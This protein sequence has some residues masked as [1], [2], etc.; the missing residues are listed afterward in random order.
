MLLLSFVGAC[1]RQQPS[2]ETFRA[3]IERATQNNVYTPRNA[4]AVGAVEGWHILGEEF[5]VVVYRHRS[6]KDAQA[7]AKKHSTLHHGP[8][9]L[10]VFKDN[11][12]V[13]QSIFMSL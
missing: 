9:T 2:L 11:G 12:Q 6:M 4:A 7:W 1:R 13:I 8:L 10:T 5:E 3:L